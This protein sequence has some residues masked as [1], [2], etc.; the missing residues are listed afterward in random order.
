MCTRDKYMAD[1]NHKDNPEFE[2]WIKKKLEISK[3]TQNEMK[4][5]LKKKWI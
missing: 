4:A 3:R 2:D 5:E 1:W